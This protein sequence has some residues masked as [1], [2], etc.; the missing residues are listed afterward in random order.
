[1]KL[2]FI[3]ILS[4][5]ICLL[6]TNIVSAENLAYEKYSKLI[7]S[8]DFYIEY[9][10]IDE[11]RIMMMPK[12]FQKAIPKNIHSY[13]MKN[14]IRMVK[15]NMNNANYMESYGRKISNTANLFTAAYKDE[16]LYGFYSN[17]EAYRYDDNLDTIL[18]DLA[19]SVD[20]YN[21]D[22]ANKFTMM[23]QALNDIELPIY[24]R[25]YLSDNSAVNY[26]TN[27]PQIDAVPSY[28]ESNEITE[29]GITYQVD[30]YEGDSKVVMGSFVPGEKIN[31]VKTTVRAY[32]NDGILKKLKYD[33]T[34]TL[35]ELTIVI[36]EF[37]EASSES[38]AMPKGCTVYKL[39]IGDMDSLLGNKTV[40][41]QY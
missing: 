38:V 3:S 13:A 39:N 17:K 40:V 11:D 28:K 14:G 24:F 33:G 25:I 22:T 5:I 21:K 31:N 1:M 6:L 10:I 2:K 41:E 7:N 32:Y 4:T 27:M 8:G 20:N 12:S 15:A 9:E 34:M 35:D 29:N 19:I 30:V 23:N 18:S 26:L 16:K 37:S 36:N